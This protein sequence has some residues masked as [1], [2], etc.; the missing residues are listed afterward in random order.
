MR[1]TPNLKRLS[2]L[3]VLITLE[4]YPNAFTLETFTI[5][6]TQ[7]PQNPE[8]DTAREVAIQY[9]GVSLYSHCYKTRSQIQISNKQN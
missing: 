1:I 4:E 5:G 8:M 3:K 2:S 6:V 9:A 7:P